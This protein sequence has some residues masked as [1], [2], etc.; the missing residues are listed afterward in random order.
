ME[1]EL[2]LKAKEC[3]SVEELLNLAKENGVELTEEQAKEYFAKMNPSNG[4]L[5]DDELDNVAGG[6]GE[7][8]KTCPRCGG[9]MEQVSVGV[10]AG[11]KPSSVW[12]CKNCNK[13]FPEREFI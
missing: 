5:A 2:M 12:V 13:N 3:K 4:E 9:K 10:G 6:C 8:E 7:E 11:S 1:K